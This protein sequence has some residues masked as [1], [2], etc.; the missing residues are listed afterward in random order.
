MFAR[1]AARQ[2]ARASARSI[3]TIMALREIAPSLSDALTGFAAY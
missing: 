2:A 1:N 3:S